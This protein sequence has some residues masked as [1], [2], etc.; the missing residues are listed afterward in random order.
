MFAVSKH[1]SFVGR[2][3]VAY[4]ILT[5]AILSKIELSVTRRKTQL[6]KQV[7]TFDILSQPC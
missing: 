1:D 6:L 3:D 7:H 5:G 4:D 2:E